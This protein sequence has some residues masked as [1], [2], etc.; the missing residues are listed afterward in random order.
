MNYIKIKC[1]VALETALTCVL[2]PNCIVEVL[3]VDQQQQR[4]GS[5]QHKEPQ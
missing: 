3:Q 1:N 2:M 5:Q 4:S